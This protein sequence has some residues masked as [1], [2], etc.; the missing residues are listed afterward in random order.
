LDVWVGFADPN[1]QI[2]DR[3]PFPLEGEGARG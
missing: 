1:I 3:F 2:S